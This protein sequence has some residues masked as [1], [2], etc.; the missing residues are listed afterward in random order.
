MISTRKVLLAH[1]ESK[2]KVMLSAEGHR[3]DLKETLEL[4][5][6][7]FCEVKS[8]SKLL[9]QEYSEDFEEWI[10]EEEGFIAKDKQKLTIVK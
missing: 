6:Q 1:G 4:A 7:H 9:V 2:E 3:S 10:D 5:W 8:K